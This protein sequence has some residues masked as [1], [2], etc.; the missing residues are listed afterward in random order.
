MMVIYLDCEYEFIGAFVVEE[1]EDFERSI[2]LFGDPVV[3]HNELS[4]RG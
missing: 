1:G 3:H 4:L 2:K